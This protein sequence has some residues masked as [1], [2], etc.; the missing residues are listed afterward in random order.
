MDPIGTD[1]VLGTLL[2]AVVVGI[3][4]KRFSWTSGA[5]LNNVSP[6][7]TYLDIS[8][9]HVLLYLIRSGIYLIIIKTF[10]NSPLKLFLG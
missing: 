1:G 3:V 9:R 4:S 8:Y 2:H 10:C 5:P 6:L 7:E